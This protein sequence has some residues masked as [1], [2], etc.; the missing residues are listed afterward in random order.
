MGG[1]LAWEFLLM[2]FV[3]V[4]RWQDIRKKDSVNAVS[5]WE[6]STHLVAVG[7]PAARS[8]LQW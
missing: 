6:A 5:A 2:H 3:E 4:R 7:H 8:M 1:I